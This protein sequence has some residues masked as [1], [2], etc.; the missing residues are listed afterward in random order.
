MCNIY[1]SG[2]KHD[3]IV[4]GDGLRNVIFVSGCWWSCKGCHNPTTHKTANGT[5]MTIDD[6]IRDVLSDRN[7]ITLSGGD[8]LTYQIKATTNLLKA[9]KQERPTVNIWCYTGYTWEELI[10][11][12]EAREALNYIDV[13]VDGRYE[14]DKR[15]LDLLFRGSSNQRI[16][17][18]K[19]SLAN[20]RIIGANKYD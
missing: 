18:V 4:D 11:L 16:I 1:I 15:D 3:S 7:D 20:N 8:P 6:V 17:D 9:L 2:I 19:K 14:A 12:P 5:L 13:L 10:K